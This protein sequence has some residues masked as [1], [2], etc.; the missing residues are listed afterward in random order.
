MKRLIVTADDFGLTDG[1][2]L[3]IL[4]ALSAGV[5]SCTSAMM[6]FPGAAE[7][8]LR[9][10]SPLLTGRL[11]LHVQVT[12]GHSCAPPAEVPSLVDA[13]GRFAPSIAALGVIAPEDVD[14]EFRAQALRLR[15]LGLEPSH[16]DSHH[17]AHNRPDVSG[18][19]VALARTIGVARTGPPHVADA[20]R[21]A[22]VRHADRFE[23]AWFGGTLTVDRLLDV[24]AQ[25][26]DAIGG[27]GTVELMCH[28]GR[29]DAALERA[30]GY[31]R[32]RERELAVF[33]SPE[34]RRRLDDL[35]IE[36]IPHGA[37]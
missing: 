19:F 15:E 26:F 13:G 21:D 30:S 32:D 6:A 35:G 36:I 12:A 24:V 25:A 20:L 37:I 11:G 22:G 2:C 3:A 29:S 18:A 8:V 7:R 4:D 16:V 34:L 33:C 10:T 14:R 5:V 28:P 17:H 27:S 1:V 31:A 9:H 23:A